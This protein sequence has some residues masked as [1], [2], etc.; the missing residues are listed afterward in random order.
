MEEEGCL[1]FET[2]CDRKKHQEAKLTIAASDISRC[3]IILL[4]D[5]KKATCTT[6]D[7]RC[8]WGPKGVQN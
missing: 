7:E 4:V 3:P 1:A 6:C 8:M 5:D 2:N